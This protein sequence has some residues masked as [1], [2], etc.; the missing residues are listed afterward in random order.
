[1]KLTG[2]TLSKQYKQ[3]LPA[4]SN[5]TTGVSLSW[6]LGEG[7]DFDFNRGWDQINQQ[8]QI[9]GDGTDQSWMVK[10][11]ELKDSMKTIIKTPKMASSVITPDEQ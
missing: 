2:I 6:E 7:E 10:H 4:Y 3:G 8:L 9:Q 5:L 1:M 11:V